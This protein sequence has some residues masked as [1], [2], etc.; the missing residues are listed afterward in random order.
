MKVITCDDCK[1][2][3]KDSKDIFTGNGAIYIGVDTEYNF[4]LTF[5]VVKG[6]FETTDLDFCDDCKKDMIFRAA[7]G[8]VN[9]EP[10]N[11]TKL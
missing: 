8:L 7:C 9:R 6:K 1:Q 3:I 4:E 10:T 2:E 5:T 11:F